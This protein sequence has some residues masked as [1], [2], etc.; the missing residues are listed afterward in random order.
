MAKRPYDDLETDYLEEENESGF[1]SLV[2]VV[3][4]FI[5]VAVFIALAWYAYQS[6][7]K[8]ESQEEIQVV[9]PEDGPVKQAPEETGGWQFPHQDKSVYNIVSGEE[10]SDD[11][12]VEQIL[13]APEQPVKRQSANTKTW[14]NDKLKQDKIEKTDAERLKEAKEQAVAIDAETKAPVKEVLSAE[15]KAKADAEAAAAAIAAEKMAMIEAEKAQL[16]KQASAQESA[17]ALESEVTT[18]SDVPVATTTTAVKAEKPVV[19]EVVAEK[20]DPVVEAKTEPVKA[21]MK[22]ETKSVPKPQVVATPQAATGSAR[23]Q[24][25]A[26]KSDAD[27]RA[28]WQKLRARHSVL[29]NKSLNVESVTI[30]GKG[31]LYRIQAVGFANRSAAQAACG[32]ISAAG[33]A[34]FTV[35]K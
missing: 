2:S 30:P 22:A 24:L 16:A 4:A 31:T 26:V 10:G 27:A 6:S 11:A 15:D 19:E 28:Q 35:G 33:Q 8:S 20:P 29:A 18:V 3:I 1:L 21:P 9:Y 13:P 34:C 17:K 23:L 12:K 32:Q 14:M 25:G 5:A 7:T